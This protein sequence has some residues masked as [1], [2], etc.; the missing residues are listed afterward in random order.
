L[1][2]GELPGRRRRVFLSEKRRKE[3]CDFIGQH[4]IRFDD[5]DEFARCVK[6]TTRTMY[7][8]FSCE[9]PSASVDVVYPR[10]PWSALI[11]PSCP[12]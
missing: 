1:L 6:R 4:A 8:G 7:S 12:M 10:W 3:T 2:P 5:V 11:S 9:N